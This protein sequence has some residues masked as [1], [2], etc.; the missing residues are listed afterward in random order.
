MQGPSFGWGFLLFAGFSEKDCSS[1]GLERGFRERRFILE[2]QERL[3]WTE[4]CF[5][6]LPIYD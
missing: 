6:A 5:G 2:C 4:F 3:R 1:Q